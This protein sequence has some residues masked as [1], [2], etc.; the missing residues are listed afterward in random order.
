[1][2]PT[3]IKSIRDSRRV[4][5]LAL[6]QQS[7]AA[8]VAPR[9]SSSGAH[10]QHGGQGALLAARKHGIQFGAP[11][12]HGSRAG[13]ASKGA[14]KA[15][16]RD[17]DAPVTAAPTCDERSYAAHAE[18]VTD[19]EGARE[20]VESSTRA[21]VDV[22][23]SDAALGAIEVALDELIV[24]SPSSRQRKSATQFEVVPKASAKQVIALSES[25]E[26]DR[27][28]LVPTPVELVEDDDDDDWEL[29][30]EYGE[31]MDKHA[32]PRSWASV[33]TCA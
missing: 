19:G 1:M 28:S 11:T 16:D 25:S 2:H 26:L 13:G 30:D 10:G 5:S 32:S 4:R 23:S 18:L 6:N 24:T 29:L 20:G 17:E 14:S 31:R 12:H 33:V 7:R 15:E 21:S 9:I 22:A 27:S 8:R 3:A